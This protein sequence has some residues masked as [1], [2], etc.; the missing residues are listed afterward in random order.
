VNV[1][2]NVICPGPVH[3]EIIKEAPGFIYFTLKNIFRLVFRSPEKAAL[4]VVY[5]SI[6]D[7]YEGKTEEYLHMFR[8]KKMDAKCYEEKEGKKLWEMSS[9]LWRSVDAKAKMID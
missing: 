9:K 6:S 2:V 1:G 8:H 3:S 5:M 4:P 7:D